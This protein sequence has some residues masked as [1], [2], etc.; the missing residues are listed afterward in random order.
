MLIHITPRL[1]LAY[2]AEADLID[3]TIEEHGLH[4]R[5]GRDL[6]AK[7]PDMTKDYLVGCKVG[8]NALDGV[9]IETQGHIGNFTAV[10]RWA[11]NAETIVTH[12]TTYVVLDQEYDTVTDNME[13]WDAKYDLLSGWP[14]RWPATEKYASPSCSQPRMDF[15]PVTKGGAHRRGDVK[16]KLDDNGLI[17]ERNEVFRIPTIERQRLVENVTSEHLAS[18]ES[19]YRLFR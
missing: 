12:R 19:A 13:Q 14:S 3:L 7:R 17:V 2:S 1:L 11:I 5:A 18:I 16:D 10:V 9:L 8:Q 15:W 4:L 6:I